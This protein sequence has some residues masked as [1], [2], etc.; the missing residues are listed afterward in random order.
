MDY[1]IVYSISCPK[2]RL[3]IK[4]KKFIDN[5]LQIY[6]YNKIRIFSKKESQRGVS[7]GIDSPFVA[8]VCKKGFFMRRPVQMKYAAKAAH[9]S[10]GE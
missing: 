9:G 2:K 1:N 6:Y 8:V 7:I 4:I 10:R 3:Y 5:L